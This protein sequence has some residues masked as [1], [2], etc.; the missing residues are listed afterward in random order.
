MEFLKIFFLKLIPLENEK[1]IYCNYYLVASCGLAKVINNSNLTILIRRQDIFIK[2]AEPNN[3]RKN[4]FSAIQ[5]SIMALSVHL[6]F[7]TGL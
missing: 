7:H 6:L 3:L 4:I 1:I 2:M 5:F